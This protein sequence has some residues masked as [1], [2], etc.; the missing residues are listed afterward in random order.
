MMIKSAC[1]KTLVKKGE[2]DCVVS[3]TFSRDLHFSLGNESVCL[4]ASLLLLS[5]PYNVGIGA[6][7]K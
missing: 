1:K 5:R 2:V 3:Y 7:L 4:P 6:G